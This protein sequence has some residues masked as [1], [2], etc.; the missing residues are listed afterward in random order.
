MLLALSEATG[1]R[2]PEYEDWLIARTATPVKGSRLGLYDG[3]AGVAYTLARLGHADAALR[4]ARACL[5]ERWERLG[6]S[7]YG[8]LAG[9]ALAMLAVGD[10]TGEPGLTDSGLRAAEI[11]ADRAAAP[12]GRGRAAGLLRGPSGQALLFTR[13]Y[14]RTAQAAWLDAAETAIAADL[15]GCVTN[16]KGALQVN[17]GWRVM[18]YLNAGSAGIGMVIDRFLPHRQNAA[19]AEAAAGIRIAAQSGYYAQAGL[20]NGRAGMLLYLAGTGG[21]DRQ[22][23]AHVPR[24]AWHA[25]PYEGGLAFPG[26]MLLRLSMDL[27]TGTA[28]VLLGLAALLAPDGAAL[29]FLGPP[30]DLPG[31]ASTASRG[32]TKEPAMTRR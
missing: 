15:D 30:A 12:A 20:F 22:A 4:T 21:H 23:R 19:F 1:L 28:G 18:P 26:D 31:T 8:G 3:L 17:E 24:L 10:F 13:L 27:G 29:P 6:S 9:L 5:D 11:V 14:E 25:V 7:L 2:V 32:S 16:R